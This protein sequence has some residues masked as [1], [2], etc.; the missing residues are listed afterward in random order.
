MLYAEIGPA[1]RTQRSFAMTR[2]LSRL[3]GDVEPDEDRH[4]RE[5]RDI[6]DAVLRICSE[7][8]VD[9]R[10]AMVAALLPPLGPP[11]AEALDHPALAAHEQ[12]SRLATTLQLKTNTLPAEKDAVHRA[13]LPGLLC[14]L[15][16]KHEEGG[17]TGCRNTRFHIFPGSSLFR[18][19]PQCVMAAELVQTT[20]LY[21]RE[22]A[23]ID[24]AWVE[25]LA[26]HLIKRTHT[27]PHWDKDAGQVFAYENNGEGTLTLVLVKTKAQ[28]PFPPGSLLQY[29][30]P[31][32][33]KEISELAKGSS[34][35]LPG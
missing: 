28:E 13:M 23:R 24:P 16:K 32:R 10:C 2:L 12:L 25:R 19:G 17:Y 34:L 4:D 27:E 30:T 18:K 11:G 35:E 3:S 1:G 29:I 14:N 33:D 21:A 6:V 5:R 7:G 9:E 20:K 15:G 31:E 22:V 26:A 8:L